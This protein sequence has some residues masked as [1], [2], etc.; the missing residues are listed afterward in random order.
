MRLDEVSNAIKRVEKNLIGL[1]NLGDSYGNNP[2]MGDKSILLPQ[3][4]VNERQVTSLRDMSDGISKFCHVFG[5]GTVASAPAKK[6]QPESTGAESD[7]SFDED[8]EEDFD[9]SPAAGDT[10]NSN[11]AKVLY[12]FGRC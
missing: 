10:G 6:P 2:S 11:L 9:G 4:D 1:K 5:G 12:D 3:I 7:G 8:D